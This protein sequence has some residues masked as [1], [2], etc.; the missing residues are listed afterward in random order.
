MSEEHPTRRGFAFVEVPRLELDQLLEQLVDRAQEVLATQGRLRGLL[1]AHRTIS[2]DLDLPSVLRRV[3]DAAREL[4]GARYAA[5][6]VVDADGQLSRF[7]HSATSQDVAEAVEQLPQQTGLL[8]TL[9]DTSDPI[10]L[11]R[12]AA[13]ERS[14]DLPPGHPVT[15]GFLG[16]PIRVR[17]EN[18]GTLYLA[19]R[20]HGEFT[21]EDEELTVALG[22]AAAVAIDNARLYAGARTRADWLRAAAEM[23]RAVLVPGD[24]SAAGHGRPEATAAPRDPHLVIAELCRRTARA[25]VATVWQL[26]PDGQRL[27]VDVADGCGESVGRELAVDD[28]VVRRVFETASPVRLTPPDTA[29]GLRPPDLEPGPSMVVPFREAD[30]V[31]GLMTV[32]RGRGGPAFTAEDTDMA[33]GFVDQSVVAM[34]L[35]DVRAEQERSALYEE[36]DRIATDLRAN[37]I[38]R[39]FATGLSLHGAASEIPA[40]RAARRVRDAVDELDGAINEVRSAVFALDRSSGRPS[41]TSARSAT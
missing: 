41:A 1:H 22:A 38:Q 12:V 11:D 4:V 14:V 23:T 40:G 37:V 36:R 21:A 27:R 19:D 32:A 5:L 15:E 30:T 26:T 18:F 35:A 8:G 13:R 31:G 39:L 7:V 10:R 6:G 9:L 17:G 34:A 25:D 33:A 24:T 16:V 29:T 3:V 28:P 2:S 20:A